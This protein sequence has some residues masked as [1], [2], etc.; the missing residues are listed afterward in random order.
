M[1][2]DTA[3]NRIVCESCEQLSAYKFYK[4]EEMEKSP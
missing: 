2:H 3:I 4:L 1:T